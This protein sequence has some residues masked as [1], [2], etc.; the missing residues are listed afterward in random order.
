MICGAFPG[1][2]GQGGGLTEARMTG[3]RHTKLP[4]IWFPKY[5]LSFSL[6]VKQYLQPYA[7][8]YD[9]DVH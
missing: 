1:Y 4:D 7:L 9:G 8:I 3:H 5:I 2:V 6:F